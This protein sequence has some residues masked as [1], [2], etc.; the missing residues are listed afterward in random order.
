[1]IGVLCFYVTLLESQFE[2]KLNS[3]TLLTVPRIYFDKLMIVLKQ[4]SKLLTS[5]KFNLYLNKKLKYNSLL[6][7]N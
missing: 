5:S 4:I 1:M 6:H 7:I 2:R 3:T